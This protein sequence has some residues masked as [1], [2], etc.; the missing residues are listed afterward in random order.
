MLYIILL[1]YIALS[2]LAAEVMRRTHRKEVEGLRVPNKRWL[3]YLIQFTWGLPI[4][5]IGAV[6]AGVLL[7][8]KKRPYWYEWHLCFELPTRS[9]MNL[10]IFVML[11]H[12][13]LMNMK[14]HEIGHGIQNMYVGPMFIGSIAITSVIRFWWRK[15]LFHLGKEPKTQYDDVWFEGQATRLGKKFI[16]EKNNPR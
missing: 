13:A 15:L 7:L 2:A 6:V 14:M 3:Y 8:C 16:Q 10:G 12:S 1:I 5:I 11:P 4:N 9:G